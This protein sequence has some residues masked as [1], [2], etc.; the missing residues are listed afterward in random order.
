MLS[1]ECVASGVM[2]K[3]KL[4]YSLRSIKSVYM[5]SGAEQNM[6]INY[7]SWKGCY[8]VNLEYVGI[9]SLL[10]ALAL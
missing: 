8:S 4:D 5:L 9:I 10:L 7:Y 2:I 3:K 1:K 6:V